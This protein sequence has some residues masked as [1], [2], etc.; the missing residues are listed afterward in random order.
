M[1]KTLGLMIRQTHSPAWPPDRRSKSVKSSGR[2]DSWT[3][4]PLGVL[5]KQESMIGFILSNTFPQSIYKCS[6]K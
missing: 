3:A 5:A 2:T 6:G 4:M 1:V